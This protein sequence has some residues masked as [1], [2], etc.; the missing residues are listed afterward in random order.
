M[1]T[2]HGHEVWWAKTPG[3][4]RLL[5]RIGETNDVLTYLGEYTRSQIARALSPAAAARMV[6]LTPGVD[7]DAFHPAVD[8]AAGPGSATGWATG[9]SSCASRG[10]WRARARTC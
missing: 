7:V 8:G 5:R 10:W 1:A 6:Q 4:R 2:T 9:R 3:T